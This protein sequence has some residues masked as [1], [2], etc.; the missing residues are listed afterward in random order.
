MNLL[1]ALDEDNLLE[2][3]I[4]GVEMSLQPEFY[5]NQ[6]F[7]QGQVHALQVDDGDLGPLAGASKVQL[8]IVG[9]PIELIWDV[10]ASGH[11]FITEKDMVMDLSLT[12]P[13]K[14]KRYNL[15]DVTE[16]NVKNLSTLLRG[17]L[18]GQM[19][20][21]TTYHMDVIESDLMRPI[22]EFSFVSST[23]TDPNV[24]P[25]TDTLP[26][27][28]TNMSHRAKLV[29]GFYD[30]EFPYPATGFENKVKSPSAP[31][32]CYGNLLYLTSKQANQIHSAN[33]QHP[34]VLLRIH[35][36][37]K[38]NLQLI[39][40]PRKEDR[41]IVIGDGTSLR[42]I[43]IQLVDRWFQPVKLLNPMVVTIKMKPIMEEQVFYG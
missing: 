14:P 39:V 34:G 21:D 1:E 32:G 36:F 17:L 23:T 42:Q 11:D 9:T 40:K 12:N 43:D 28:F 2:W 4:D 16:G 8:K 27:R 30:T 7:I 35:E 31:F 18:Q 20:E 19:L 10:G 25:D 38:Y 33:V 5:S 3:Y 37:F 26:F 29:T 22:L 24:E 13:I 6:F 41:D 15:K